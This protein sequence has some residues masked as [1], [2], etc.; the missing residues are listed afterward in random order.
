MKP[1]RR[2]PRQAGIVLGPEL[3][4]RIDAIAKQENNGRSATVRRLLSL[5]LEVH[6]ARIRGV[7]A[8]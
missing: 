6:D 1:K 2:K 3:T 4:N 8:S 7:A 5:G